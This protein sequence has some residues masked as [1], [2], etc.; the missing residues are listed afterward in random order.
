MKIEHPNEQ[1]M[2]VA[3]AAGAYLLWGILPLYWKL[4]Y[5]IPSLEILAHRVA[6]SLLFMVL[7][8]RVTGKFKLFCGELR[9]VVSRPKKFS[10][11][12]M[13]SIFIT[14]NWLTYIWAMNHNHIIE[15][16]LGYYIYFHLDGF[17]GFFTG[18]NRIIYCP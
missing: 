13:A 6:W 17:N 14:V 7:I 12:I 4:I 5:W 16:S 15:T 3:S 9:E 1:L 8:L 2:G 18:Q 10:G 11:V